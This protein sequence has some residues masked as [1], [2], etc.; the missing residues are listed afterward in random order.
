VQ[1]LPVGSSK[2][3]DCKSY[4]L[5]VQKDA[6]SVEERNLHQSHVHINEIAKHVQQCQRVQ[7]EQ[8][9]TRMLV[10]FQG[11]CNVIRVDSANKGQAT[12]RDT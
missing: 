4:K 8:C 11:V 6:F 12:G 5:Q 7:T 9:D 2:R 3:T 1:W 10:E